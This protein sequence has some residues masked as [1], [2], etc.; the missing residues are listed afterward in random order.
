MFNFHKYSYFHIFLT[1][2]YQTG[3]RRWYIN[4]TIAVL[5]NIHCSV[6]CLKHDVSE[7]ACYPRFQV[8]PI[9]IGPT[10]GA[11][12]R[13]RTPATEKEISSNYWVQL[14]R[15]HLKTETYFG[16]LNVMF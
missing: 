2:Q 1:L 14:S 12:L 16:L 8:E 4:V 11:N 7:T 5:D 6:F 3:L 15:F 9:D 13:L 10:Y